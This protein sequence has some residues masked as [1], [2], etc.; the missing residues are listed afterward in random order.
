MTNFEIDS[1]RFEILKETHFRSLRNYA[2][3]PL[4]EL[5]RYYTVLLTS[6]QCWTYEERIATEDELTLDYMKTF[7]KG[8]FHKIHLES[9]ACGNAGQGEVLDASETILKTFRERLHSKPLPQSQFVRHREHQFPDESS[10]VF[11]V[12]NP[13]HQSQAIQVYFQTGPQTTESNV[14]LELLSHLLSEPCF[15]MLRTQ[16]QLGYVTFS[17]IRRAFGVQGFRVVIQSDRN[18][19]YLDGRIEAFLVHAQVNS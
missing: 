8:I 4:G 10:F 7:V 2:T 11:T 1:Q 5:L 13:I 18:P 6:D 12:E 9:F 15:H 17:A 3:Q 19:E 14:L 16:E